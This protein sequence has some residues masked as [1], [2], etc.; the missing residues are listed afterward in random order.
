MSLVEVMERTAEIGLRRA[1]GFT[2]R[3]IGTTFLLESGILGAVG[4][5]TGASAGLATIV[6]VSALRDWTPV[7]DI[8]L[9][10]AAVAVGILVGLVAGSYPATKAMRTEPVTALNGARTA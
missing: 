6:L 1:L 5:V 8:W 7:L 3:D 2:P 10:P 4:G 9:A